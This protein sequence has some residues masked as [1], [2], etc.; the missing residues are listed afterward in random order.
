MEESVQNVE[1]TGT[2]FIDKLGS[3]IMIALGFLLPIFF[4][5]SVA[6]PLESG[7]IILLTAGVGLA[8]LAFII[9]VIRKGRLELP[10]HR[11]FLAVLVIPAIFLLSSIFGINQSISIF[12]Y[13]FEAGTFGSVLL[14]FLL[15]FLVPTFLRSKDQITKSF[16]GFLAGFILLGLFSAVKFIFGADTLVFK[17]FSG[18]SSNSVGAWTDLAVFFGL[19]TILTL[20]AIEML[21]LKTLHKIVLYFSFGLCLFVLS[22]LNFSI[23]W[24]VLAIFALIFFVYNASVGSPVNVSGERLRKISYISIALLVVSVLFMFNP[25][26]AG[27]DSKLADVVSRAFNVSNIDVRPSF[28]STLSVAKPVLKT[29][30]LLGSGP[31]TFAF[32]WLLYKPAG[33]NNTNFWN[34][35]FPYGFS[36]LLTFLVTTGI[37]GLF[38]W[39]LFF[40]LLIWLGIRTLFAPGRDS[41]SKFLMSSSFLVSLYLWIMI[42]LYAPGIV[43]FSLAF[44]FTGLFVA[45][46]INED[47]IKRLNISFAHNLKFSFVVVLLLIAFF[48][49]SIAFDYV[50]LQKIASGIYYQKALIAGNQ[51]N[52]FEKTA[53]DLAL[54]TGLA[55]YDIYYRTL[56]ELNII[57]M[58]QIADQTTGTTE[59]KRK[60]FEQALSDSI[61]N[62]Q[63]ARD[64]NGL[65]YQNWVALGTAYET[66]VPAPLS[67]AGAYTNA[68]AAY[69]EALKRNPYSPEIYLFLARLEVANKDNQAARDFIKKSL[70]QKND[71]VDAYFLLTQIEI[72]DNN[73]T[74]ATRAAE[75]VAILSP[76][77]PGVFFQLGLL[78]YNN[79]D[80]IGA[81]EALSKAISIVPDYAN[82]KYFLGLSMYK[83]GQNDLAIQEFKDLE[84]TNP[85][86]SDISAILK[87]LE[88]KRD[89]FYK[90]SPPVNSRPERGTT[91]PITNQ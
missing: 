59:E 2:M 80:F 22:V 34:A 30:L 51:D 12:G 36:L 20:I 26:V 33:I 43:V 38:A 28:T 32:D 86:N 65:N 70:E 61:S 71:Y 82:A 88:D 18:V 60:L 63:T 90:I 85:D 7:K 53:S 56:S 15:L 40:G 66:L 25:S 75:A 27:N 87:N 57:R 19:G 1:D 4:I 48:I 8:F 41:V 50:T 68:K 42:S 54:A 52:D 24:T 37:L 11:M 74:Q 39:L 77:N 5:P 89:P 83:L 35:G 84:K 76:G 64:I 3:L 14:G 6:V 46:A 69:E 13:G 10:K 67:V 9:S 16:L 45:A 78:K 29:N 62:A 21:T 23:V 73:L 47:Q 49:G 17:I 44:F 79:D 81:S 31:N 72:A 55:P 91:P 58:R